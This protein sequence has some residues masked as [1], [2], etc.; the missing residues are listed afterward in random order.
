MS[1]D[2]AGAR[3]T[4]KAINDELRRLRHDAR[5]D[6]GDG[7]FYFWAGEAN[8]WLDKTVNVP[9]LSSL[10]MEQW[11]QEFERLKKLNHEILHARPKVNQ[12][13]IKRLRKGKS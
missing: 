9:S 2:S 4:L 13:S 5:L 6:K 7:Y 3:I 1:R 11:V 12:Q 8:E 10:T